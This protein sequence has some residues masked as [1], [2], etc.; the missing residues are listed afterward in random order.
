MNS[1][2][3]VHIFGK[4][5]YKLLSSADLGTN[6]SSH[7]T[8]I[9]LHGAS[10][11]YLKNFERNSVSTFIY[12]DKSEDLL[13]L[14]DFITRADGTIEAPKIRKGSIEELNYN[15]EFYNS[16]VREIRDIVKIDKVKVNWYL[17]WFGLENEDL[18]F[19]L[20]KEN[21][22]DYMKILNILGPLA[23]RGTIKNS[24]PHYDKIIDFFERKIDDASLKLFD[25]I[26]GLPDIDE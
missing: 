13:C 7:Q 16:I 25:E 15:G 1:F 26:D 20:F 5:G 18:V 21:S 4:I 10:L 3:T 22:S 19:F 9:G 17:I 12:E 6:K 24:T 23:V 14:L 11:D 2:Y 8:H